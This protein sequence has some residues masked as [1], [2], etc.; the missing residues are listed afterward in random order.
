MYEDLLIQAEALARLD[1]RR[2]KQANLRRAISSTY[3][4]AF[5]FLTHEATCVIFG[6][7]HSQAPFRHVIGRAFTHGIMK[8]ACSSFGGGNLKESVIKGLPRSP[9]GGFVILPAIRRIALTFAEL[10][11]KRHF[12]D[13]DRNERFKRDDVLSLLEQAERDIAAFAA[14]PMTDD[15]RFFLA[16]L[17]AWKDLTHR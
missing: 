15:S 6:T 4:A 9:T 12:A 2:P 11:E 3:Y 7:Q 16:C 17:W 1:A 8:Q 14:L 13:Y 5:H 10:Q